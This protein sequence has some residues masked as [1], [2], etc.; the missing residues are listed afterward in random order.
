MEEQKV[1]PK[2]EAPREEIFQNPIVTPRDL[3]RYPLLEMPSQLC[4]IPLNDEDREQMLYMGALLEGLGS[5][6]LGLAAVQIGWPKRIFMLRNPNSGEITTYI[7]PTVTEKSTETARK[8]EACLSLPDF[9]VRTTRAKTITIRYFTPEGEVE[10]R[11]FMG[12]MARA[13]QHEID[14]L[15]GRLISHYIDQEAASLVNRS[16]NKLAMKTNRVQKRRA[17]NKRAKQS[18]KRN[19]PT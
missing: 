16:R 7:N 17:K 14:H 18:R 4:D 5:S 10:E 12:I 13:V 3:T 15:S 1:A 9:S 2:S 6:A 11:T 8:R 19:R